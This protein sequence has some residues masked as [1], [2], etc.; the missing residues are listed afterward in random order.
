[1][2]LDHSVIQELMAVD[3]LDGLDGDDRERLRRERAA[4]GDCDECRAL[5]LEFAEIAAQLA[6]ALEPIPVDDSMVDRILASSPSAPAPAPPA[7][8]EPL[9]ELSVRR[10]VRSR[11]WQAWSAAAAAAAVFVAI[12][13]SIAPAS[14]E[15]TASTSQRVVR[16]D[17][18]T[19]ATLAMIYTPGRPGAVFVGTG[20]DDP[21]AD[22]VY[23]IWM[24]EDRHATSGGCVVP[25]NGVVALSV[26]AAIGASDAMAVTVESADC[27][28]VPVGPTVLQADLTVV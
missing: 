5:E 16:F 13:I 22:A 8:S 24:L 26:D 20:L 10:S 23:E 18:A 21:G 3:A 15:T 28:E 25:T 12:V 6:T 17:G 9:D 7:G 4:H 1:M 14:V 11:A 27:P 19:E 2:T